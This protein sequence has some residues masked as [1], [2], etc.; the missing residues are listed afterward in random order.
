[1]LKDQNID[2]T[3]ENLGIADPLFKRISEL[4]FVKPT[5]IQHK[6]IEVALKGEDVVGIAQTGSGK[7][8]AFGI[9]MIQFVMQ[10][11]RMGLVLLPTRE[12]AVQVTEVMDKVAGKFGLR[13]A[14]LIG[15]TSSHLQR[16]Q[17]RNKPHIVIATPGRLIDHVQQNNVDLKD[18]G[19]MVL[20]EADRMLDMGFAPQL[21]RIFSFVSTER[22]TMLFSATMPENILAMA[23]QYMKKPLRIE[24]A[25]PGTTAEKID[26]EMF[27]VD[28]DEKAALL[29]RLV[30]EYQGS[31]LIFS[32]TKYGAK[33]IA[34]NLKKLGHSV[35]EIHSNRSQSQRQTALKGFASGKY[36][37]MVATDIAARG[38][39]VHHIELVINYDLPEQVEDYTHRI[40]RTGRAGRSGKAISFAM[41]SQKKEIIQIETLIQMTLPLKAPSGKDLG[42]VKSLPF[43]PGEKKR[44]TRRFSGRRRR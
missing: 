27:I 18:V 3:F 37:I 39:D 15:G 20:D 12:L 24:V 34:A 6:A 2:N 5:P 25:P 36:R 14:L 40:G 19:M 30:Q 11:K 17:L 7:T 10:K 21:K 22:Q 23:T 33:K 38:I 35:D 28:R 4:G 32:R 41:P 42:L 8:L 26:Q 1:M 13:T 44:G 43:V 9:P 16:R 31:I 29:E